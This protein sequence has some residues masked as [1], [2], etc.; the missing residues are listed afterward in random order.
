MAVGESRKGGDACAEIGRE[1]HIYHGSDDRCR[2][3]SISNRLIS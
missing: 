3:R 2:R 1:I